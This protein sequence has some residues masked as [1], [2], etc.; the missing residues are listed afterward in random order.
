MA[1]GVFNVLGSSDEGAFDLIGSEEEPE[2]RLD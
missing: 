2:S 1:R